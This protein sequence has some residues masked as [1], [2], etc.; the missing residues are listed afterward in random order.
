[1]INPQFPPNLSPRRRWSPRQAR[2][3]RAGQGSNDR[4]FRSAGLGARA[5]PG[6]R[7][8]PVI[9]PS[10]FSDHLRSS[11]HAKIAAVILY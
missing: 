11:R 10:K 6:A 2:V 1:M 4:Q 7:V 5:V 3:R 8:G 9:R